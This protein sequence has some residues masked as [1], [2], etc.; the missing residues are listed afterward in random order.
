[1]KWFPLLEAQAIL[2]EKQFW[3]SKGT[4][5]PESGSKRYHERGT[6]FPKGT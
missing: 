1:M 6:A 2:F 4:K 3:L 5:G